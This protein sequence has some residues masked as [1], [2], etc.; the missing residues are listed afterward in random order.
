MYEKFMYTYFFM[1]YIYNTLEETETRDRNYWL[2]IWK[3]IFWK[4]GL[5]QDISP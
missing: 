5:I 2:K 1:G 4:K 3:Q